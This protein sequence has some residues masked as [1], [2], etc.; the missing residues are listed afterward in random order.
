MQDMEYSGFRA[1]VIRDG[2]I[3]L[4]ERWNRK[5][6]YFVLPG[7]HL[8]AGETAKECVVREVKEELNIEVTPQAL[9]YDLIDYRKQG[10][11]IVEWKSGEIGKTDAPEYRDDRIGG[12]YEPV[13]VDL[14]D[15]KNINLVPCTLK[16]HLLKDLKKGD[17]QNREKIQIRSTFRYG[18][19]KKD[20]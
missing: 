19:R 3:A 6:H 18:R 17:L 20:V 4:I 8:E 7:G 14:D 5:R 1:I 12:D 11:Y 16:F 10:I 15:L 13:L 2:K 9:I